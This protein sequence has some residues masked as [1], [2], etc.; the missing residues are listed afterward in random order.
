MSQATVSAAPQRGSA[1][2]P[3]L[4]R[5]H[6][7]NHRLMTIAEFQAREQIASLR[8]ALPR[9]GAMQLLSSTAVS[10]NLTNRLRAEFGL[11][12]DGMFSSNKL[13]QIT[14]LLLDLHAKV[15]TVHGAVPRAGLRIW[16]KQVVGGGYPFPPKHRGPRPRKPR[17]CWWH[18][19]G[20]ENVQ[21]S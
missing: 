4:I 19:F 16:M 5:S 18:D 1:P 12:S 6:R 8:F 13:D 9:S 20:G 2:L 3:H 11:D 21:V 7:Y 17:N 15:Q 14:D 10:L